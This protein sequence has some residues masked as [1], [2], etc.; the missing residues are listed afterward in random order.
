MAAASRNP[1]S[2]Y[3]SDDIQLL[4]EALAIAVRTWEGGF[5]RT[6]GEAVGVGNLGP[7]EPITIV[8]CFGLQLFAAS[9]WC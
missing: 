3:D 7:L 2:L 1:T 5:G 6:R 4:G 8:L 9:R